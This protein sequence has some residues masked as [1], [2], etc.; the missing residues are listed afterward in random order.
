MLRLESVV[1]SRSCVERARAAASGLRE[2]GRSLIPML[3]SMVRPGHD[4]VNLF[5]MPLSPLRLRLSEAVVRIS[6]AGQ[7]AP[8]GSET[9]GRPNAGNLLNPTGCGD[10]KAGHFS[11]HGLCEAFAATIQYNSFPWSMG[12]G[13]CHRPPLA[14]DDNRDVISLG[15]DS[16]VSS[17]KSLRAKPVAVARLTADTNPCLTPR[18]QN[19]HR[20]EGTEQRT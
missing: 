6:H 19:Q 9:V 5:E 10:A 3:S 16:G 4:T 2:N 12:R 7:A 11:W 18:R 15:T 20:T 1:L 14:A 8:V 17:G 13:Q